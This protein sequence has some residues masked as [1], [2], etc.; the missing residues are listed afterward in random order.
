[1]SFLFPNATCILKFVS[2]CVRQ[3]KT[4]VPFFPNPC[5][6]WLVCHK[7]WRVWDFTI[8]A[9]LQVSLPQFWVLA[10]DI[11]IK[12]QGWK[13]LFFTET[14]VAR[15]SAFSGSGSSSPNSHRLTEK[16]PGDT[17]DYITGE[18]SELREP[19]LWSQTVN[20][21]DLCSEKKHYLQLPKL[22]AIQV[23]LEK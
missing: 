9:S 10:E 5:A 19:G 23:L 17:M 22:F 6:S 7:L 4:P 14:V 16:E 11:R 20:I 1:M 21:A 12:G 15:V 8:S 2:P 18:D 3:K 13:V